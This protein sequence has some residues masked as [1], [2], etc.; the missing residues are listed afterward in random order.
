V[1][2]TPLENKGDL[3]DMKVFATDGCTQAYLV[4]LFLKHEIISQK[5]A[6]RFDAILS[7]DHIEIPEGKEREAQFLLMCVNTDVYGFRVED[8][9]AVEP[10]RQTMFAED[11]EACLR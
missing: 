1:R 10:Q 8:A 5:E 9:E 4:G 7:P 2:H 3:K 11:W 6:N